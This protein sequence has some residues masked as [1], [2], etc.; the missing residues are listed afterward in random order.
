MPL[1]NALTGIT[2]L[3]VYHYM[4][5]KLKAPY[6][7]WQEDAEYSSLQDDNHKGEQSISGTVDYFTR[8]EF[9]D[10]IDN[11]QD[12]LNGV[13]NLYWEL[14]SVQFEDETN[15]IHYEWLFRVL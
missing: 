12:A 9:D 15:L 4:R 7:V 13:E 14:L 8:E 10:N 1:V 5:P 11:I 2:G 3:S 6:C